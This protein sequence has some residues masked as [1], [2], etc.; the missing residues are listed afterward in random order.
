MTGFCPPALEE[1][2]SADRKKPKQFVTLCGRIFRDTDP[3]YFPSAQYRGRT[4]ILC[5][6]P[7]LG[8]FLADPDLFYKAHR[9]S[10]RIQPNVETR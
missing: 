9:N 5:T 7:C 10:E 8:A 3:Q 1:D 4:L 6:E 2:I